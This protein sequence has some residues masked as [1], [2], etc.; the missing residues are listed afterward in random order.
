LRVY[1][2]AQAL[3]VAVSPWMFVTT[4]CIAL[5]L[6]A[7]K[8]RQELIQSGTAARKALEQYTVALVDRY[9]EMSATGA[10][11]FYSMFVVSTRPQLVVTIPFVLFGLYR[12]WFVVD[13]LGS[14]ESPTDVLFT[15]WQLLATVAAW[16]CLCVWTLW[17]VHG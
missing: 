10:L 12:Y 1:A 5:Y 8:R 14:G 4:L 3:G 17:P 9:A 6:A 13:A 11:V 2:G 7:I 15:D 16:A